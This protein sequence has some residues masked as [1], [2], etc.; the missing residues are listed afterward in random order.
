MEETGFMR[1]KGIVI[2]IVFIFQTLLGLATIIFNSTSFLGFS[3]PKSVII[4][5]AIGVGIS[6]FSLTLIFSLMVKNKKYRE[7]I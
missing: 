6:I 5:N 4:L 7:K 3:L 1:N 2:L